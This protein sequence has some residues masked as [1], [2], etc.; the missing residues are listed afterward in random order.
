[1]AFSITVVST[2]TCSKLRSSTAPDFRPASMVFVSS[3]STPSSPMRLRQR[4]SEVGSIGGWCW[5][6]A[7]DRSIQWIDLPPN[8]LAG[9]MLVIRVL[10]PS[11]DHRLVR[12]PEGML[13]VEQPRHQ[14]RR[15]RRATGGRGK[16]PGPLPFEELP[17]GQSREL[18]QL[19][20]HVDEV[21]EPWT[22]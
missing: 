2:A 4:V 21:D 22:E 11:P 13:E 3:H 1:M 6:E 20:A 15:G 10:D 17:V 9:E 16:E 5:S 19:M 12:Q 18:H 7:E 8:G 14:P